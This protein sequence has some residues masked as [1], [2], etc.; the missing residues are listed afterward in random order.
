[1]ARTKEF[2]QEE[3][4]DAA[5]HLFWEHGYEATSIQ[6]L[7]EATGVQR[8]SLYDTFGSKHELFLQSL[9]RYQSLGGHHLSELTKKHPKGGLPLIRA[10]FKSCASQTVCDARG[11]FAANSAAEL[12]SSDE[13]VAERVRIGRDGLEEVFELC[14]VQARDARELKNSSS[15][16]ALAQF[17]VNAFFGLRLMAKTRPSKAMIDNVVSVTLAALS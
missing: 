2:D 9:M 17:L 10:I 11:C 4:L 15:V 3:A 6:E 7:V 5:M 12:G 8:Q 1:M 14:L 13:A 16:S